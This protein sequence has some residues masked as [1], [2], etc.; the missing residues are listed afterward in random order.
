ML[1]KIQKIVKKVFSHFRKEK[2]T[3]VNDKELTK[4]LRKNVKRSTKKRGK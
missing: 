4:S 3:V 2:K 1:T